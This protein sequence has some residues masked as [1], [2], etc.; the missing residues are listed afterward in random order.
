MTNKL[1]RSNSSTLIMGDSGTGKSTLLG[2]YAEWVWEKYNK[3]TLYYLS[4]GGGFGTNVEALIQR[5][6][7]WLWK[8]RTRGTE[9]ALETCHKASNGYWPEKWD[10]Q[11]GESTM[12][13]RL[14]PPTTTTFTLF[15]ECGQKVKSSD[16]RTAFQS[17]TVCPECRKPVTI[18]LNGIR[19]EESTARTPGFEQVGAVVYDGLS[20]MQEWIMQDLALRQAKGEFGS[21]KT[22]LGGKV[23]SGDTPFGTST[24]Q[25][26]GFSQGR[27]EQWILN[28]T[29]IPGLVA[30][31]VWTALENKSTDKET[32]ITVYGPKMA[33]SAKTDAAPQWF[34]NCLGT[35]IEQDSKGRNIYKLYL[36]EYKN[37]LDDVPHL[38]KNRAAP[39][40][41][42][43]Y[44]EDSYDEDGNVTHLKNFNLGTFFDLLDTALVK[45]QQE[46]D[47][48]LKNAPG[49]PTGS[50]GGGETKKVEEEEKK[51]AVGTTSSSKPIARP[52]TR[53]GVRPK[54]RT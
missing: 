14:L 5:G 13:C 35:A 22:N 6:V 50:L 52:S 8:I 45:T 15:C 34:G 36:Q 51:S 37:K 7:I 28:S 27:A 53:V 54:A 17:P 2:T 44:L 47:K 48:R 46:T 24:M 18:K 4:D 31:P 26:Y 29:S 10:P 40:L 9:L 12:G 23:V 41:L 20:S 38:C 49:I 19:V 3:V 39:G 32:K 11:T 1:I 25:H 42:P 16:N 33:G 21:D 43:E 30:S